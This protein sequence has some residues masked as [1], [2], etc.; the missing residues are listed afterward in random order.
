MWY[1][2]EN[3]DSLSLGR[4]IITM[5]RE[6]RVF[7]RDR[8]KVYPLIDRGEGIYLY[9]WS[10]KK[11][12]D[13]TGGAL[14]VN[15]GHSV[16]EVI[17][18]M[19][20]QAKKVCFPYIGHFVS[21]SQIEL[22]KKVID[23]APP[24]MSKVYF[25]SG[26]SEAIEI[27]LKLIRQ[28]YLER[29]EI[30]RVKVIGRWQGYHGATIG[31]LSLG[32]QTFYRKD[33]LPYMLDFPHIQAPYCYRC[34]FGREYSSCGIICAHELERIIKQEGKETIAAFISE[35]VSGSSL[36]AMVPPPEYFPVI[37]EICDR[38]G[39]LL[40]VDEVVT[41]FG[42]TG[43]NFGIDHW[44]VVPDL[45]ITGKGI[46]SGYTPLGAVII[47]EK[48]CDVFL[49]SKRTTFFLGYTYSGN[50]LSC[51]VGLAVLRYIEKHRLV[52]RS[53]SMGNYLF[54]RFSRLQELPMVGDIRGKGLLLGIE[55]VQDK[56]TKTPFERSTKIAETIVRKAFDKGL[57]L[58]PGHGLEDGVVGDLL[59]IAP[60]F[61][62][63]EEEIKEISDILTN[64]IHEVFG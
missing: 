64:V 56:E 22:A 11:Y 33:Y 5:N 25:V 30:S 12:I 15:I 36:G 55:L 58:L 2:G 51:A 27:A 13:A 60:P 61:I 35:P 49:K 21:Q 43:K 1:P 59:M 23:F 44:A 28:Y 54:E 3:S 19:V 52:E 4:R 34:R 14:V 57:I 46:S 38:Y 42:R 7:Y 39:I 16:P 29:G 31:A 18:A 17:D 10:G 62:V 37:R 63:T 45:I 24:G 40:V 32:G 41:G 8:K 9:D 6:D 26:G 53:E 50:P 47:H 20:E 48:I